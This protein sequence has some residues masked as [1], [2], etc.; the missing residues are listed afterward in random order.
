M[1]LWISPDQ[2]GDTL[3][4]QVELL[5]CGPVVERRLLLVVLQELAPGLDQLHLQSTTLFTA[6]LRAPTQS[7]PCTVLRCELRRGRAVPDQTL[8][9][10]MML[11][12]MLLQPLFAAFFLFSF[13][14]SLRHNLCLSENRCYSR[15]FQKELFL[16]IREFFFFL[17][18]SVLFN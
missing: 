4:Q 14:L 11:S 17:L 15:K 1:F 2:I 6:V 9:F 5:E 12:G 8:S 16:T 18:F 7:G 10:S 13:F 3:R